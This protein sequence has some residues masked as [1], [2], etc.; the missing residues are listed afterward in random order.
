MQTVHIIDQFNMRKPNIVVH[1]TEH[2]N[3]EG[4]LAIMLVERWGLVA[5]NDGGEDSSG[6][7]RLKL[8]SPAE[9]VDR[10]CATAALMAE[11]LRSRGWFTIAPSWDEVKSLAESQRK[12]DEAREEAERAARKTR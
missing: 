9:V 11:E 1:E 6:R 10:A 3:F 2:P 7:A 4:R 12:E 8:Q 5:A